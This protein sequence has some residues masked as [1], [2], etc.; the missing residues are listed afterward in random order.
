MFESLKKKALQKHTNKLLAQRDISGVNSK[1]KTLAFLVDEMI[2]QD[3]DK[4]YDTYKIFNLQPKDVKVFSFLEVKK[5]LPTLRQNQINNKDFSWKGEINNQNATEFLN[6]NFDVLVGYYQ[7]KHPF[8]DLMVSQSK[9]K[10]KVGFANTNDR[11]FDLIMGTSIAD[12]PTFTSEL[13]K[14]VTLLNKL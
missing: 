11:L 13:K 2:F 7:G 12:F 8:L 3:F 10:F 6:Q 4:L 9:A 1:M 14:Y 5:K